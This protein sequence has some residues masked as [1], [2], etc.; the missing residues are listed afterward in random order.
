MQKDIDSKS[1]NAVELFEQEQEEKAIISYQELLSAK[2]KNEPKVQK[3]EILTE[4]GI[5]DLEE[6][7]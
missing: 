2:N 3:T 7:E 4:E 1:E 6:K 5:L